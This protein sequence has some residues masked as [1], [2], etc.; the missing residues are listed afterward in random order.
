M[1]EESVGCDI[2][3][4]CGMITALSSHNCSRKSSTGLS[5]KGGAKSGWTRAVDQRLD[6]DWAYHMCENHTH[7][8]GVNGEET[9]RSAKSASR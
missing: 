6:S 7:C 3:Y 5:C 2:Y 4:I 1:E 8:A 9:H